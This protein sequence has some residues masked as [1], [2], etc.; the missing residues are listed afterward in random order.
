MNGELLDPAVATAG[1]RELWSAL[2]R[3]YLLLQDSG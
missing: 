1:G 3:K 2:D